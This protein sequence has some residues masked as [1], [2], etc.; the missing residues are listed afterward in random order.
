MYQVQLVP[1]PSI[2]PTSTDRIALFSLSAPHIR[3]NYPPVSLNDTVWL[4]Q[5][6]PWDRTLQGCVIEARVH[7][8]QRV[9]GE[10]ILRCDGLALPHM[11]ESGLFSLQWVHSKSLDNYRA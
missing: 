9:V 11:W 10:V 1:I 3:E 5:L 2:T 8:L 7:S 6:R 4:R